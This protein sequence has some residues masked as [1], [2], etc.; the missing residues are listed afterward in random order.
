MY[1]LRF[2]LH[3]TRGMFEY[4]MSLCKYPNICE[5]SG[6]KMSPCMLPPIYILPWDSPKRWYSQHV[7]IFTHL[8]VLFLLSAHFLVHAL[9]LCS[10]PLH[11]LFHSLS[12][13]FSASTPAALCIQS[14][15]QSQS[16]PSLRSDWSVQLSHACFSQ[17]DWLLIVVNDLVTKLL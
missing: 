9:G 1:L 2:M 15:L 3:S 7:A 11:L 8:P 5:G 6:Y 13:C 14:P 16:W 17:R 4:I 12:F 10:L